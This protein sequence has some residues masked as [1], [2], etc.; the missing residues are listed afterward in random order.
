M[1]VDPSIFSQIPAPIFTA[2]GAALVGFLVGKALKFIARV[3]AIMA[4]LVVVLLGVLQYY[5]I[6]SINYRHL[7]DTVQAQAQNAYNTTDTI[8]HQLAH[9]FNQNAGPNI[10][11]GGLGFMGGMLVGIRT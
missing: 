9:G 6:I 11:A 5:G 3:A 2:G 7:Q 1:T 4:G 10:V 8:V